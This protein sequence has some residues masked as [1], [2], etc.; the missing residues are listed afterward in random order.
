MN[1][2]KKYDVASDYNHSEYYSKIVDVEP[3]KDHQYYLSHYS[4]AGYFINVGLMLYLSCYPCCFQWSLAA[5]GDP[6]CSAPPPD[7]QLAVQPVFPPYLI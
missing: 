5:T 4:S 2:N 1:Y 6:R 7:Q 3:T